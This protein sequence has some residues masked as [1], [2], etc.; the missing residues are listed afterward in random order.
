MDTHVRQF[1]ICTL[2]FSAVGLVLGISLLL[3]FGG[4]WGLLYATNSTGFG[5]AVTGL[6][7]VNMVL[8]VPS[9][10]AARGLLLYRDW[11][12]IAMI[13]ICAL[14]ILN[15]PVGSILGAYGLWV[16]M[17][18]ETE[19]LFEDRPLHSQGVMKAREAA[20]KRANDA[21]TSPAV[22]A[23]LKPRAD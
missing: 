7:I 4:F 16:L 6:V 12:R 21:A 3:Y 1:A 11:A 15:L 9:A 5:P 2:L 23:G 19:P 8:A 13:V 14:N 10:V 17:S 20:A 18:P 22:R